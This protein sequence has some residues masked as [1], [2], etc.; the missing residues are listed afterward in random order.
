MDNRKVIYYQDELNDEFST[1]VIKAKKI[2]GDYIY[3]RH[4]PVRAF[5]RFFWYRIIATPIA[6]LYVKLSLH[7][8]TVGY[9]GHRRPLH[10]ERLLL[11]SAG[12]LHRPC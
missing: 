6:F 2:D 5:T 8:K 11:P 4:G 7:Q 3:D 9:A 1:A 10:P 12:L